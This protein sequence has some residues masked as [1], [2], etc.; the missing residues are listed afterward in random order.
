[1]AYRSGICFQQ[2]I[3]VVS[4]A[5]QSSARTSQ[6]HTGTKHSRRHKKSSE[7]SAATVSRARFRKIL[8]SISLPQPAGC[9][10]TAA[11]ARPPHALMPALPNS[12]GPPPL[13]PLDDRTQYPTPCCSAQC[14][15]VSR[16]QSASLALVG[17]GST[18]DSKAPSD[19]DGS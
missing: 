12:M 6:E 10:V 3:K 18:P 8:P 7:R 1:M 19:P 11:W 16:S 4:Q 5:G 9:V 2:L 15:R 13:A 14:V 17:G